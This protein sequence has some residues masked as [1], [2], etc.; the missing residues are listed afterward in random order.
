MF[1]HLKKNIEDD[2]QRQYRN[3]STHPNFNWGLFSLKIAQWQ[4]Q[5]V[6]V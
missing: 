5:P 4:E 6:S 2:Y 3:R 1:V